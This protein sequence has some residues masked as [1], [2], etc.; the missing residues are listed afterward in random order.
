M[1]KRGAFE[2]LENSSDKRLATFHLHYDPRSS[3]CIACHED[4][5]LDN[6]KL[7]SICAKHFAR[8]SD[9]PNAFEARQSFLERKCNKNFWHTKSESM[10]IKTLFGFAMLA[11]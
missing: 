8:G 10:R 11:C 6:N 4:W 9:T 2:E 1:I 3:T 5:P 7:C